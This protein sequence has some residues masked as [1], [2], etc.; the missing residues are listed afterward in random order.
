MRF[1]CTLSRLATGDWR[2]R[3]AGSS[4]GEVAVTAP[5]R[6]E[7]LTKMRH[8]LRYRAEYCPCNGVSEDFVELQV[9]EEGGRT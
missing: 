4:L 8:E 5:T 1:A 7:A 6:D 9:R 2:A 3:H